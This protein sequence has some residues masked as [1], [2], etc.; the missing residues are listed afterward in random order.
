[1]ELLFTAITLGFV[2]SFH[3][4]GMC[5]P[6]TLALPISSS[7]L[8]LRFIGSI[9]YNIGRMSTYILLGFVFFLL[10]QG[11]STAITQ[12][13]LAIM[14]GCIFLLSVIFN[15]FS[16]IKFNTTLNFFNFINK[17]KLILGKRFKNSTLSNLFT[18]G[19]LNGFLPCGLVYAAIGNAITANNILYGCLAMLLFGIGTLPMMLFSSFL[20]H[21]I[22]IQLRNK[23]K[24]FVPYFLILMGIFFIVRGLNLGI[25]YLSPKI[26][27]IKPFLQECTN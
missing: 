1:M 19:L 9:I 2:G 22:S 25:P 18:I 3:C 10:G 26:N 4:L 5:G 23:L 24:K 16:N 21:I 27:V 12:Q 13:G 17:I 8:Y 7:N 20:S 11:I 15:Y 14:I 6:I